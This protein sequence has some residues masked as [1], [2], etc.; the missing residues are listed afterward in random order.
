MV[1]EIF[2]NVTLLGI[3]VFL[4]IT[5]I[6]VAAGISGD[7]TISRDKINNPNKDTALFTIENINRKQDKSANIQSNKDINNKVET[8]TE[9][10]ILGIKLR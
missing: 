10:Y 6:L 5:L 4:C 9:I 3:K 8:K 2:K 7:V 1:K